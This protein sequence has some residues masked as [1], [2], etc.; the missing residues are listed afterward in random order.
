[1]FQGD[2]TMSAPIINDE[3]VF[4]FRSKSQL[5]RQSQPIRS[6]FEVLLRIVPHRFTY[7]RC[8]GSSIC[9]SFQ[10]DSRTGSDRSTV[11]HFQNNTPNNEISVSSSTV[12]RESTLSIRSFIGK[13]KERVSYRITKR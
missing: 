3:R 1:M 7:N 9:I 13:S 4:T 10:S 8:C 11:N 5:E 6:I 2:I 12:D